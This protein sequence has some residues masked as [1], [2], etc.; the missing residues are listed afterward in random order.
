MNSYD[1]VFFFQDSS[2]RW[3]TPGTLTT[4][5]GPWRFN[6]PWAPQRP[7]PCWTFPRRR[8]ASAPRAVRSCA[9]RC[10]RVR[11]QRLCPSGRGR[12]ACWAWNLPRSMEAGEKCHEGIVW[13][14]S[15]LYEITFSKSVCF[16]EVSFLGQGEVLVDLTVSVDGFSLLFSMNFPVHVH[17]P[18]PLIF[19]DVRSFFWQDTPQKNDISLL[20]LDFWTCFPSWFRPASSVVWVPSLSWKAKPPFSSLQLSFCLVLSHLVL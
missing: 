8:C 11:W 17:V 15:V 19:T 3:D 10:R 12:N 5:P 4:L 7:A 16:I 6:C 2:I 9:C 20:P 13:F 1:F 14:L 18:R